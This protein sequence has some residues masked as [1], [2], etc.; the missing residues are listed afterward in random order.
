MV[1]SRLRWNVTGISKICSRRRQR[2]LLPR[3]SGVD[4]SH[5]ISELTANIYK[6]KWIR[7]GI[8]EKEFTYQI[9]NNADTINIITKK[10]QWM[11]WKCLFVNC[12]RSIWLFF[13]KI[14]VICQ[15]KAIVQ[16]IIEVNFI[17]FKY[18]ATNH[19]VFVLKKRPKCSI[20]TANAVRMTLLTDH[21]Y[22]YW[23]RGH[24]ISN[25]NKC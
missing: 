25:S 7:F 21:W 1:S 8:P 19:L 16:Q 5:Y 4:R 18:I 9:N 3:L 23:N 24:I 13:H 14:Y 6:K 10:F 11:N 2:F 20:V 22:H 17:E 15:C 12:I